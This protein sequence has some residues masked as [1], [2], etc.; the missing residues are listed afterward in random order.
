M[1]QKVRCAFGDGTIL[2]SIEASTTSAFR[3][4]I[5]LAYGIAYVCASSIVHALPSD[6]EAKYVRRGDQMIRWTLIMRIAIQRIRRKAV[7]VTGY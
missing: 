6:D 1:G 5:Q 3:Y 7:R 4:K 2:S